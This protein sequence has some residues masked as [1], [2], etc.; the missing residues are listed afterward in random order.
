MI[1]TV[2]GALCAN[3]VPVMP[4]ALQ[5]EPPRLLVVMVLDVPYA[6]RSPVNT[7]LPLNPE[8]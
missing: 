4:V 2:Y 8:L 5:L 3:G 1:E 7:S 6:N